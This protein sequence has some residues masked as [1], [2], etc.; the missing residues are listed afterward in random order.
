MNKSFVHTQFIKE[1]AIELGFSACGIAKA[2][3]LSDQAEKLDHWLSQNLHGEMGYMANHYDMRLDPRLLVPGAK[4]VISLAYN[5][6]T[7]AQQTDETAPKISMYAFGKDY[8]TVVKEKLKQ[9]LNVMREQIGDIDGRCF[10]DSAPVMERVWA[11]RSGIGWIGKNTLLLTKAKGSYFFL[12]EIICDVELIPDGPVTN[13]CGHCTKCIDAC[14]TEAIYAPYQLDATKCISYLTIELKAA[15]LPTGMKGK[16]N[17]WMYGCDICQQV[18][19]INARAKPHTEQQFQPKEEL[20]HKSKEEWEDITEEVF[21][22]LFEQSAVKRT[23][24]QGLK[25]NILFLQDEENATK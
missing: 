15:Q 9:L 8:H 4:S 11:E 24:F 22:S 17:G 16:M 5:Y 3:Y 7:T 13:Y 1:K 23:R 2:D 6:Y 12:A 18:C 10:V 20:L 25:R 19:P 21:K 14:P